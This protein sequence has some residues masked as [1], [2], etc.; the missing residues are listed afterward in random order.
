[1]ERVTEAGQSGLTV[2]DWLESEHVTK[3]GQSERDVGLWRGMRGGAGRQGSN[4]PP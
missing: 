2:L 1:M 4:L 3:P